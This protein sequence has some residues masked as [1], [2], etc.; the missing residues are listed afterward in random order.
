MRLLF[1][2]SVQ[3]DDGSDSFFLVEFT[4]ELLDACHFGECLIFVVDV[5]FS[6]QVVAHEIGTVVTENDSVWVDHRHNL[7]HVVFPQQLSLPCLPQ[8]KV[9]ETLAHI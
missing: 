3:V 7:E 2:V 6:V 9:N 1:A 8:Q 5:P 4:N